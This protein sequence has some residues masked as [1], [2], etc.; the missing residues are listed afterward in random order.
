MVL[1]YLMIAWVHPPHSS[2]SSQWNL[3]FIFVCPSYTFP[4]ALKRLSTK[5]KNTYK[6]FYY[7]FLPEQCNFIKPVNYFRS[8]Y[9][10]IKLLWDS[11]WN[12]LWIFF[13]RYLKETQQGINNDWYLALA[14]LS[15]AGFECLAAEGWVP[16]YLVCIGA[17]SIFN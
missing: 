16:P 11:K 10:I 2:G 4:S 13:T 15:M 12:S 14:C 17:I 7:L 1:K 9:L 3:G 5:G 8:T 6:S